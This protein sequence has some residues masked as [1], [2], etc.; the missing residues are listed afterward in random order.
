MMLHGNVTEYSQ[1][2]VLKRRMMQA[3]FTH[4]KTARVNLRGVRAEQRSNEEA[5]VYFC[6]MDRIEVVEV[7]QDGDGQPLP[8]RAVVRGFSFAETG[9]HAIYGAI[10]TSNGVM[11]VRTD[12]DT[13]VIRRDR[14]HRIQQWFRRLMGT[15]RTSAAR[16]RERELV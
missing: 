4:G 3:G 10:L 1:P 11:E 7:L 13:E 6:N 2:H 15:R 5:V 12:T 8:E 16:S 14:R 9:P